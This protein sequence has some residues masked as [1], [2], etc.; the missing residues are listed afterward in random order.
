MHE[1][2]TPTIASR[3]DDFVRWFA[4]ASPLVTAPLAS[5]ERKTEVGRA[6]LKSPLPG[7]SARC[8]ARALP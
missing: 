4:D 8:Q 2:S 1:R 5:Q 7:S 6:S 3:L